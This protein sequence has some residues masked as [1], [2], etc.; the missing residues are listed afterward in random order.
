MDA[1]SVASGNGFGMRSAPPI[2]RGNNNGGSSS[3]MDIASSNSD[4]ETYERQHHSPQRSPQDCKTHLG[5]PHLYPMAAAHSGLGRSG[6][7]AFV[8]DDLSDSATSTEVSYVYFSFLLNLLFF[9]DIFRKISS[10]I[11]IVT[12]AGSRSL[13]RCEEQCIFA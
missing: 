3:D 2:P 7:K 11:L 10:L 8:G 4:E 5:L 1:K 6:A 9:G 13:W 12:F